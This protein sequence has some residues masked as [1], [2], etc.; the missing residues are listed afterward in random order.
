MSPCVPRT[1][2]AFSV[3]ITGRPRIVIGGPATP[4]FSQ[5]ADP[6]VPTDRAIVASSG[7]VSIDATHTARPSDPGSIRAYIL[8]MFSH[9]IVA[10]GCPASADTATIAELRV[11]RAPRGCPTPSPLRNDRSS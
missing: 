8:T 5:I 3:K 2:V 9:T 4:L 6:P 10:V 7:N 1:L 11:D